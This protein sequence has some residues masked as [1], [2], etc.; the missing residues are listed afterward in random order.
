MS[1]N[2]LERLSKALRDAQRKLADVQ[3]AL[4]SETNEVQTVGA[5]LRLL[6]VS[7]SSANFGLPLGAQALAAVRSVFPLSKRLSS[8]PALCLELR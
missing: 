8:A 4:E 7:A 5:E 1:E 2:E 6:Q 3:E